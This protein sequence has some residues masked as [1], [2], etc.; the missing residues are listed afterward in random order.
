MNKCLLTPY[1]ETLTD[2]NT[3]TTKVQLGEPR[4]FPG[5]AYRSLGEELRS[6][7]AMIGSCLNET[8]LNLGNRLQKLEI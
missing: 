6:R 5:V 3:D 8:H 7:A 2:Q 4:S 1:R